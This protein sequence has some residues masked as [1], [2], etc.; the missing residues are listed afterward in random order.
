MIP[1]VPTVGTALTERHADD[2]VARYV[3]EG[4]RQ[5]KVYFG[6]GFRSRDPQSK[7]GGVSVVSAPVFDRDRA[8]ILQIETVIGRVSCAAAQ[9]GI[10]KHLDCAFKGMRANEFE[11]ERIFPSRYIGN[12]RRKFFA[13]GAERVAELRIFA[14]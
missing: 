5:R 3:Q 4:V 12:E 1:T 7:R 9:F 14:H 11:L 8:R 10:D 6:C 13:L 2:F